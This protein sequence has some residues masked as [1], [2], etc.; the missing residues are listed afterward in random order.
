MCFTNVYK[1][2]NK[3]VFSVFLIAW[4]Q[5]F[6]QFV[7]LIQLNKLNIAGIHKNYNEPIFILDI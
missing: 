5:Q 3:T 2:K 7:Q 1:L 4:K 6:R